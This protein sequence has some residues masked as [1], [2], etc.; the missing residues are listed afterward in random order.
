M[1][2]IVSSLPPPSPQ[3]S[4]HSGL[5]YLLSTSSTASLSAHSSICA[6]IHIVPIY[7]WF[8]GLLESSR[9]QWFLSS[10]SGSYIPDPRV[11]Q[12]RISP[13]APPSHSPPAH[14]FIHSL[15]FLSSLLDFCSVDPLVFPSWVRLSLL[16]LSTTPIHHRLRIADIFQYHSFL[17]LLFIS[18]KYL[19]SFVFLLHILEFLLDLTLPDPSVPPRLAYQSTSVHSPVT[20]L[21]WTLFSMHSTLFYSWSTPF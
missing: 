19:H 3:L 14:P 17:R 1:T 8:P 15:I 18:S 9:R 7:W 21:C 12:F 13:S 16:D 11:N 2:G 6:F 5:V 20:D 4:G 10:T